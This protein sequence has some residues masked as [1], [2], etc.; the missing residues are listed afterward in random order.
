MRPDEETGSAEEQPASNMA[1]SKLETIEYRSRSVRGGFNFTRM[2]IPL[3]KPLPQSGKSFLSTVMLGKVL[4][5]ALLSM[6]TL[7]I[8]VSTDS[9]FGMAVLILVTRRKSRLSRSIQLVVYIIP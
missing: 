1:A 4:S 6:A 5:N 2:A 7:P 3:R 8:K 9:S